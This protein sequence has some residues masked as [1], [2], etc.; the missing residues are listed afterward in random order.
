MAGVYANGSRTLEL[1]KHYFECLQLVLQ[2]ISN[3][4]T[5]YVLQRKKLHR[6]DPV[7][8]NSTFSLNTGPPTSRETI[9]Y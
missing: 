8:H 5:T 1:T 3:C 2:I 4:A 6:I 7:D 9:N